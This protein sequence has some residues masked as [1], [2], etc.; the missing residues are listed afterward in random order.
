ML[1]RKQ[2]DWVAAKVGD[3]LVMM[4]AAKGNYVGLSEIGARIWEIIETPQEVE[5]LCAQLQDEYDVSPETCRADVD[6]FLNDL[7]RQGAVVFETAP[8]A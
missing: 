4:S 5:T 1:V 6:A 2:G 7:A 8:A 3:A